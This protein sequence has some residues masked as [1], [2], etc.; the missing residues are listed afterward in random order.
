MT[1]R[2]IASLIIIGD[3]ILRG[4][5]QDANSV[6]LAKNLISIGIKIRRIVVVPDEVIYSILKC[7]NIYSEI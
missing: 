3:E 1:D 2:D 5:V 6:Y 4:Q 7:F